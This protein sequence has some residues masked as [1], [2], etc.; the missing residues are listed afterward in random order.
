MMHLTLSR[1]PVPLLWS[2]FCFNQLRLAP[3]R[4]AR[5]WAALQQAE[6][7]P[8]VPL[9]G[10]VLARVTFGPGPRTLEPF[11]TEC[12]P[13]QALMAALEEVAADGRLPIH[14]A[15]EWEEA[16]L[17]ETD[18]RGGWRHGVR[19]PCIGSTNGR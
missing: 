10:V 15:H 5:W 6:G 18:A 12:L 14:V 16:A 9:R 7:K 17:Q 4:T 2:A 1:T 8:A 19:R 11:V 3:D 13:P